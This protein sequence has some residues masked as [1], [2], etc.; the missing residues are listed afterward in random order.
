[1]EF[2]RIIKL[3]RKERGITQKQAAEDLHERRL[4]RAVGA[5]EGGD[6]CVSEGERD[7]AQRSLTLSRIRV[8]DGV[9]GDHELSLAVVSAL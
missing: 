2:N 8:T 7:V 3:L 5:D 1:M 9:E 6:G 4:A